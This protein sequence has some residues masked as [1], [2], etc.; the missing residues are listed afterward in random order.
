MCS[1]VASIF[2][3]IQ[4]ANDNARR[5]PGVNFN[6][7]GTKSVLNDGTMDLNFIAISAPNVEFLAIDVCRGR[8]SAR[9]TS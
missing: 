9:Q 4:R 8:V 2:N 7:S 6:D 3:N 1:A 5:V